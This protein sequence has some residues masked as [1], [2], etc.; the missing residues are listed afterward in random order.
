MTTL[1]ASTKETQWTLDQAHSELNFKVKHMMINNVTG[2]FGSFDLKTQ[3]D[4]NDFTTA[5]ITLTANTTS[6]STNNDTR[7]GHLKSGDFFDVEH[8]PQLVF[9]ST[10]VEQNDSDSY[11][12]N[13][14]LTIKDVT[15]PVKLDVEFGGLGVDPYGNEKAGFSIS[16]KI[17]RTEWNLTWNTALEAG[18]FLLA[19]DVKILAEIQLNKS[20]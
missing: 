1:T 13:G 12:L 8:F 16:G 14:N 9:V 4:G 19:D 7:D 17:N 3:T 15:K 18:G 6:I 11:T 20:K 5:E 2:T 10:S